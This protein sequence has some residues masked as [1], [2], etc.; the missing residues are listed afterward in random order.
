[1]ECSAGFVLFIGENI[2][3]QSPMLLRNRSALGSLRRG[4]F[5]FK[6]SLFAEETNLKLHE[7][8]H[9]PQNQR[10]I[11]AAAPGKNKTNR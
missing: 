4:Y 11:V 8:I 6:F 7:K 1:M 10:Y 5:Y 3:P 2:L 9:L